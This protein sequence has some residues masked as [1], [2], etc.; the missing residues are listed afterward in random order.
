MLFTSGSESNPKSV[1]LTHANI[2]AD[3]RAVTDAVEIRPS[4]R[5]LGM[6]PA[7]HSFGLTVTTI[8]A[9]ELRPAGVLLAQPPPTRRPWRR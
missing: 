8:L 5:L 3:I 1:P 9:V 2:L 7:F 4:D 6:L